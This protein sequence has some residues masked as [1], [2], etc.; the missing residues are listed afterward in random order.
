VD[1]MLLQAEERIRKAKSEIKSDNLTY[2][3]FYGLKE[4]SQDNK[5]DTD[6]NQNH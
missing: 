2:Y 6:H 3:K 1:L 5:S 4:S